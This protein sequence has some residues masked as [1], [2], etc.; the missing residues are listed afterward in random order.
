MGHYL[1]LFGYGPNPSAALV[2]DGRI[3]AFAEEER[4]NRIKTA[5]NSLPVAALLYCLREAGLGLD[6]VDGIG[7]GWESDRYVDAMPKFYD[8]TRATYPDADPYNRLQEDYLLNL[9]HPTRIRTDLKQ[10]LALRGVYL[11]PERVRFIPHHLC[12]AASTYYASGFPE[13]SIL[14]VDGSGEEFSTFMWHGAGDRIK[15]LRSV[16]LPHSLGGY[17]ATFT[18]FL[19]FRAYQD[20]GKLMGLASYGRYSEALQ[21]KL[22]E[23][24]PFDR[25]TGEFQT[26]PYLRYLGSRTYGR[27]FTDRFVAIFGKPR[28][29]HQPIEDR[30]RDLAF[31]VQWRLEQVV[32]GLI[33]SLV[34]LTGVRSLCLAGGV[35]MNCCMN[36]KLSRLPEVGEIFVQPASADNGIALGAAWVLAQRG[37]ATAFER[38]RHAY[39]GP[40][41]PAPEIE[42]AIRESKL[43]Y[44]R[45]VSLV[46]EI[47]QDLADGRIVGWLQGRM[48]VGARALGNRSILA[49]PL[50]PDMK[51]KLNREVKHRENWRPFCPSLPVDDYRTYFDHGADSDY[52]ILAYPVREA[53]RARVPSVVHVDGTARPQTVYREHNPRFY[54]LLKAFGRRTGHPVLINTSFNVQGEPIVCSPRDALRCFGGTGLD[55]L[56]LDDF[57]LRKGA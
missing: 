10:A 15:E 47:A 41:Y 31:N 39:W 33:R 23:I 17:Y 2:R 28:L 44:T 43:P 8:E 3:V 16:R 18:E 48:E 7:F 14:T 29:G 36:G 13:A 26:N 50:F 55:V 19:G 21:A 22:D 45:P 34:A 30:H 46:E 52:M 5:P 20:E 35:A 12:H 40:A 37:G 49:S 53:F 32:T 27:R 38:M 54:D 42:A 4:F 9:Y 6:A 51:D 11:D 24:L 25:A 1:G 57:V 56:V